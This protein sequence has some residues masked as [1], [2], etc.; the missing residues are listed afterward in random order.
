MDKEHEALEAL[1]AFFYG[2]AIGRMVRRIR[3]IDRP[4]FGICRGPK[5]SSAT[6]IMAQIPLVILAPLNGC[7][8]TH[9]F[10]RPTKM[11]MVVT[12][13]ATWGTVAKSSDQ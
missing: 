10:I 1:F 11:G 2:P 5:S 8:F 13:V 12:I 3:A 4:I 6:P 7:L 9:R